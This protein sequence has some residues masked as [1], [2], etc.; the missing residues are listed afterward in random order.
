MNDDLTADEIYTIGTVHVYA[1]CEAPK[2]L[3]PGQY[4][5]TDVAEEIGGEGSGIWAVAVELDPNQIACGLDTA[6]IIAHAEVQVCT[7]VAAPESSQIAE[8]DD[9]DAKVDLYGDEEIKVEARELDQFNVEA[10]PNPTTDVLNVKLSG[11]EKGV[12]LLRL[13]NVLGEVIKEMKIVDT[14]EKV[15]QLHLSRELRN[16]L[17]HLQVFNEGNMKIL[18]IILT[19]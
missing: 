19:N 4:G 14:S 1:G 5:N 6:Y 8:H 10:Y 7:R 18:P 9:E 13:T 16:G 17:Y 2:K 12:T 15:V 3:A 11:N